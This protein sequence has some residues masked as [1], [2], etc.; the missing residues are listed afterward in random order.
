MHG[1]E[2]RVPERRAL[3]LSAP[4]KPVYPASA[5]SL[6]SAP[7]PLILSKT[8]PFARNGLSLTREG[9]RLREFRPGVEGPGL[10]LRSL[11]CR[12]SC[13][14][15][16]SAPPPVAGSPQRPAASTPQA[17]CIPYRP[18]LPAVLPACAPLWEFSLPWDQRT[19]KLRNRSVR[20][21]ELPDL[22]RSPQPFHLKI[23]LRIN[24]PDPLHFRR[25]AVPQTSWNLLYYDPKHSSGQRFFRPFQPISTT[26]FCCISN[27]LQPTAGA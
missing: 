8:G 7:Q 27:Q 10:P 5:S 11:A 13:P 1:T 18:A 6:P 21:P 3:R 17:R 16:F 2:H 15:G 4:R 25:L 20:L 22:V 26:S 23:R 12:S 9:L 24:V 19:G 14:F